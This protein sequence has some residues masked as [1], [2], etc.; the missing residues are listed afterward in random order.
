MIK[1]LKRTYFGIAL[2]PFV[3]F[4]LTGILDSTVPAETSRMAV[5]G[6][7]AAVL[8]MLAATASIAFP[9]YYRSWFSYRNRRKKQIKEK[10][11]LRFERILISVT[12]LTPYL[13]FLSH[14]LRLS[15]FHTT[16]IIL[17]SL[18]AAYYF[19]PSTRRINLDRVIFRSS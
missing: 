16:A 19:Y 11:L 17:M 13:A 4:T 7:T 1:S 15:R 9:I 3:G 6:P 8:L 12:M 10:K 5:P 18:Y 14:L 2:P